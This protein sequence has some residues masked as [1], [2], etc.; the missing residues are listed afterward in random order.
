[1]IDKISG[2]VAYVV[3]AFAYPGL[4][5]DSY[6]IPWGKLRYD[7]RLGGYQTD[8]TESELH[9]APRFVR[10]DKDPQLG[11]DQ[12]EELHTYFRIPPYW[13]AI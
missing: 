8:I 7:T 11:R 6:V 3:V 2:Q 12:E 5:D 10:G 1:M 4:A 9:G 13:R